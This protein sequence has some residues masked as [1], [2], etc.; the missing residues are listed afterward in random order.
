MS[1]NGIRQQTFFL[2]F[3]SYIC[4]HAMEKTKKRNAIEKLKKRIFYG[5]SIFFKT[6]IS[7]TI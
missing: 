3:N 2:F 4:A 7:Y 6:V 5:V 1:E